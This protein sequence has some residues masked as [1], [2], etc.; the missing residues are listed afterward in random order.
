MLNDTDSRLALIEIHNTLQAIDEA[1]TRPSV[2]FR[3]KLSRDGDQWC[4]LLGD[5]LATGCAGFG[6]SVDIAASDF[7]DAFRRR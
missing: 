3:P 4:F 1:Y 2:V 6:A 5:D 7:D